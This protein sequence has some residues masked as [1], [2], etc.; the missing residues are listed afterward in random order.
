M[1]L[2]LTP[3]FLFCLFFRPL[4]SLVFVQVW[5]LTEHR[6]APSRSRLLISLVFVF[7]LSYPSHPR[8]TGTGLPRGFWLFFL[9]RPKTRLFFSLFRTCATMTWSVFSVEVSLPVLEEFAYCTCLS[10]QISGVF[11]HSLSVHL[12]FLAGLPGRT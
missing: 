9:L 11:L 7:S 3:P 6:I 1:G 2:S 10:L 5:S 8:H 4:S 12:F